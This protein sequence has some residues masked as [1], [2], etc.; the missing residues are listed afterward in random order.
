MKEEGA[1]STGRVLCAWGLLLSVVA[2]EC[3]L[4]ASI[5]VVG[6][7]HALSLVGMEPRPEPLASVDAARG[8]AAERCDAS[9]A[10]RRIGAV[11]SIVVH[12]LP[13]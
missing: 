9:A 3:K 4:R 12:E 6:S 10:M 11:T 7:A 8:A 5:G 1:E 2:L 13:Q